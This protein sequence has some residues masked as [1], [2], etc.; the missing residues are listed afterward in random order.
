MSITNVVSLLG[1]LGIFLY[2]M[3]ILSESLERA[4]GDRLQGI[5]EALTGNIYKGVLM[6][7]IVTA[8]IQSSSATTVMVVG[9]V[10][11]GIMS[12]AQSV[13]VILGANIGTTITAWIIS[14]GD[15]SDFFVLIKPQTFS[16]IILVI[17]VIFVMGFRKN[18]KIAN[19]GSVFIGF[20]LLFIGMTT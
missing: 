16:P 13:G 7:A 5:I 3:G 20:G 14:L 11:A 4:A 19:F 6:G 15:L 12:L 2:G 9:F 17:G 1:G 10:N 18:K 8:L